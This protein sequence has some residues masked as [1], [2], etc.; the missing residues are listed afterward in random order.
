MK[1]DH[2]QDSAVYIHNTIAQ[3]I[4]TISIYRVYFLNTYIIWYGP[5]S[6]KV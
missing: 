4:Y 6:E 2:I 1:V 3:Y 5:T